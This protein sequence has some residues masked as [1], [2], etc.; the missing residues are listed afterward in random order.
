MAGQQQP[1]TLEKHI[2]KPTA[3]ST[4]TLTPDQMPFT[5][6]IDQ[7]AIVGHTPDPGT[8]QA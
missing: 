5:I 3:V 1:V 7:I 6:V 8:H 4:E 2:P